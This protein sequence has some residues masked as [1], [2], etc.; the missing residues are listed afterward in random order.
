[1]NSILP[2]NKATNEFDFTNLFEYTER[3]NDDIKIEIN[4]YP[5]S[6]LK[7]YYIKF[8]DEENEKFGIDINKIKIYEGGFRKIHERSDYFYLIAYKYFEIVE[9]KYGFG[10]KY[11]GIIINEDGGMES[12]IVHLYNEA[13]DIADKQEAILLHEFL[14][15]DEKGIYINKLVEKL[16]EDYE[17]LDLAISE[18]NTVFGK[19][20]FVIK[21]IYNIIFKKMITDYMDF[22]DDENFKA[23]QKITNPL[24]KE[25]R[26]FKFSI[27][28]QDG[29]FRVVI[30][31][32]HKRLI[33]NKFIDSKT[34]LTQIEHL[35][36][37]RRREKEKIHWLQNNTA[38]RTFYKVMQNENYIQDTKNNHWKI[39]SDFFCNDKGVS[40]EPKDFKDIKDSTSN[41][42]KSELKS[43]FHDLELFMKSQN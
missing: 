20:G 36:S 30:K 35:F 24:T 40:Y 43:Y 42:L 16:L 39:L 17:N 27:P 8:T 7:K 38:L 18:T 3:Y 41:R 33:D 14:I 21:Q 32:L 5:F 29:G 37:N 15:S 1:M 31:D 28:L 22:I 25:V 26:S 4:S 6:D 34:E 23:L 13:K 9:D 2:T 12:F 19:Y 11:Q 10:Y